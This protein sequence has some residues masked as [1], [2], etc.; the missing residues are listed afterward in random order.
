MSAIAQCASVRISCVSVRRTLDQKWFWRSNS[1][2]SY[3]LELIA[4]TSY[5][6]TRRHRQ[7]HSRL[8]EGTSTARVLSLR[9]PRFDSFCRRQ[10]RS[11][12]VHWMKSS[13]SIVDQLYTDQFVYVHIS[14]CMFNTTLFTYNILVYVYC[15]YQSVSI[16]ICMYQ[17]MYGVNQ[18]PQNL[19]TIVTCDKYFRDMSLRLSKFDRCCQRQLRWDNWVD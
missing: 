3:E 4:A 19:L 9:L 2:P 17:F 7:R 5:Q 1:P 15:A 16:S 8:R 18:F 13:I 11:G 12:W 14:I 10:L 6:G